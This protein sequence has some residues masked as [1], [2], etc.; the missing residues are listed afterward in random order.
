MLLVLNANSITTNDLLHILK[1]PPAQYLFVSMSAW[2]K[3]RWCRGQRCGL[4][5]WSFSLGQRGFSPKVFRQA[6]WPTWEIAHRSDC[7]WLSVHVDLFVDP[8]ESAGSVWHSRTIR[9]YIFCFLPHTVFTHSS[10]HCG[11][12]LFYFPHPKGYLLFVSESVLTMRQRQERR[13][14]KG[15]LRWRNGEQ[16]VL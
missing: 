2:C 9:L 15:S 4:P 7:E 8:R 14:S 1:A 12:F 16:T 3:A 11:H 5:G 10:S 13:T 6:H